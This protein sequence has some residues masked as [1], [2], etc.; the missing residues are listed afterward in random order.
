VTCHEPESLDADPS[1]DMVETI[2]GIL[3]RYSATRDPSAENLAFWAEREAWLAS[4][5]RGSILRRLAG[6]GFD[7]VA[8]PSRAKT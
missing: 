1:N 6:L 7:P 5:P 4:V 3:G 8:N 2:Y